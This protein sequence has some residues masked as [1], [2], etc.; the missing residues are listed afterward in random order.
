MIAH[1]SFYRFL[2]L[3]SLLFH[4]FSPISFSQQ[5]YF[6]DGYHGGIYGHIPEWQTRF[7]V[8]KLKEFPDWYINLE[9]E[10]ESWDTIKL[11]DRNSYDQFQKIFAD[12]SLNGR[13]EYVNPS[14]GQSYLYN[15]SG[16]SVIRQFSYGMQKLKEHFP[17]AVFSTYSSEEPCFTSALPQILV[18]LGF[19]YA[20]LKNPNTCWGGYTRAYGGELIKWV[21]PDGTEILTVPRYAI[22]ALS[23][24]STW[25]TDAWDNSAGYVSN[26][27]AAGIRNP[28]GMTL[29]D[30][31]WKWG[32]WINA[33]KNP[34]KPFKYTTWRGYFD[35]INATSNIPKWKF[36][37]DDVLTS[38]VWGSQVLQRIA[39][40][41]RLA[42][43]K[44]V[45]AEKM[46]SLAYFFNGQQYPRASID[47]AWKSLLLA[48]HHDCWNRRLHGSHVPACRARRAHPR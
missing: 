11:K 19:K 22:E 45:Q 39:Q 17:T 34:Y 26:A 29:Q 3:L 1:A 43:N 4:L 25:Q 38:L 23:K 2:I 5:S 30:A 28:V 20:S 47:E 48:Q 14:Y 7:M 33:V 27:F 32:P 6:V 21:G 31:G 18:S 24:T 42:E 9:L 44:L 35:K 12:Q 15:I 8:E 40:Q 37:Q 41:V 36:S 46:A 13:V 10:P 16:E